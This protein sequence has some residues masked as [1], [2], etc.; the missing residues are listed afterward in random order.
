MSNLAAVVAKPDVEVAI[1]SLQEEGIHDESRR[2][3]EQDDETVAIPITDPPAATRVR[4]VI[5]QV[6]PE[7]RAPDL[8]TLLEARGFSP[9]EIEAA[10]SSWAVIGD[11][12]LVQFGECE[13]R[14]AVAEALLELHRGADTVLHRAGIAGEKREPTVEVVAGSGDTETVHTEHGTKYAL[15]LAR[16]M[17]APGNKTERAR[18][19]EVVEAGE[20]VLDM[21]AGIGYFS[22]PMAR[23]GAQVT[24][25]E[26]NPTAFQYLSENARLN[27]VT[28]RLELILGDCREVVSVRAEAGEQ[29]D[30][31]VMGYYDAS[32]YL[33]P[34]MA[35]LAPGGTVHMHEA[36]P[37]AL[38][39]DR[40]V[41]R[42]EAAAET[43]GR[44]V[45]DIDRRR[46]KTHSEG[47]TH[48][49][50]DATIE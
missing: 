40:P 26:K 6:D 30:R 24:A 8:P 32:E 13:R 35:V 10:P 4:D 37:D 38:L 31:I 28:D 2:L 44:T 47:V 22:L 16:V 20:R 19:G 46:V 36:T 3:V 18:M 45:L 48:V 41:E 21:F 50:L 25:V 34:A 29:Y 1:A 49:V 7:P 43:A 27:D 9:A 39:W 12:I 17:F 14:E 23:A 33:D 11:V 15:D 42:L 5:E